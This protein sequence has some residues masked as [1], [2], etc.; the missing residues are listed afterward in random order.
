M[1]NSAPKQAPTLR[2]PK[3]SEQMAVYMREVR[4]LIR[5]LNAKVTSLEARIAALENP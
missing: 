2:D 1:G 4:E 3:D 5:S